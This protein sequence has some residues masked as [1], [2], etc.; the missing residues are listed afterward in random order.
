MEHYIK[1]SSY[2]ALAVQDHFCVT[3]LGTVTWFTYEFWWLHLYKSEEIL[4]DDSKYQEL[5]FLTVI[6]KMEV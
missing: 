1:H 3:W 4:I 5:L 6:L 2:K